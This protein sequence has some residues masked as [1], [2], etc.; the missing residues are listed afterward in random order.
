MVL[1]VTSD[2]FD[3]LRIDI[4]FCAAISLIR[5]FTIDL[6]LPEMFRLKKIDIDVILV[7]DVYVVFAVMFHRSTIFR[8]TYADRGY[9]SQAEGC[10]TALATLADL[11]MVLGRG[12]EE[13]DKPR[14]CGCSIEA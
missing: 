2:V 8:G 3:S 13:R 1:Y 11:A 7:I 9:V 12:I 6:I 14:I 4:L 5:N 10:K